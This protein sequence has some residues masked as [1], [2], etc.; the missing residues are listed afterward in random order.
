MDI[1]TDEFF[2]GFMVG[3]LVMGI[4]GVF[5]FSVQIDEAFSQGVSSGNLQGYEQAK[6]D[7]IVLPRV[8]EST[9]SKPKPPAKNTAK[10]PSKKVP[11]APAKKKPVAKKPVKK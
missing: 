5:W 7:L 2:I 6:L 8:D 9:Q 10:P 11:R 1:F 4:L 3:V